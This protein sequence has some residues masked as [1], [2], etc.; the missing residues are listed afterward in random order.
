VDEVRAVAESTNAYDIKRLEIERHN[1]FSPH[2]VEQVRAAPEQYG[3]FVANFLRA[4]INSFTV[5]H[6]GEKSAAELFHR[7]ER[8]AAA[9]GREGRVAGFFLDGILAVLVRK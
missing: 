8:N 1:F 2:Q 6:I 9:A 3:Q 7:L 4:G 5:E